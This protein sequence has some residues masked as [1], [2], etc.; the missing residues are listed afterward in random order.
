MECTDEGQCSMNCGPNDNDA[1][2]GCSSS[3]DC[4]GGIGIDYCTSNGI[5]VSVGSCVS[6]TDCTNNIDNS[7]FAIA[8]CIGTLECS[9]DGTCSQ[10][11]DT[12][13][14]TGDTGDGAAPPAEEEGGEEEEVPTNTNYTPCRNNNWCDIDNEY[15]DTINDVCL[16]M[17]QCN[18]LD[19]C[20]DMN[21]VFAIVQ[22]VGTLSCTD[23]Q[24]TKICDGTDSD[25]GEID[26]EE[27]DEEEVPT[28]PCRTMDE[29]SDDGTE[30]CDAIFTGICLKMGSCNVISNCLNRNNLFAAEQCIGTLSCIDNQCS[31]ICNTN[32]SNGDGSGSDPMST[33]CTTDTDCNTYAGTDLVASEERAGD[34]E[35]DD[36]SIGRNGSYCAQGVCMDMGSCN[37]NSD[38]SNPINLFDDIRCAGYLSC[39]SDDVGDGICTRNC[40]E[41]CEDGSRQVQCTVNPCDV[42]PCPGAVS[43]IADYCGNSCT[44]VYYGSSGEASTDCEYFDET[45]ATT[46]I[47]SS[48]SNGEVY[49]SKEGGAV[50]TMEE[51]VGATSTSAVSGGASF[52]HM[53]TIVPAA[54]AIVMASSLLLIISIL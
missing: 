18:I 36:G 2:F 41:L 21:N 6:D 53:N 43:C 47:S 16:Q 35:G 15:C 37:D 22:C 32:G 20:T 30:Y 34:I 45:A 14:T 51:G 49:A 46:T 8:M 10:I 52:Y 9:I 27:I 40:G 50:A 39:G 24:C 12:G 44:A 13:D 3:S 7:P 17:G 28:T 23:G 31:I 4:P 26:E 48:S 25:E 19:D 1:L 42:N 33:T 11:C 29:C 38:C 54:Y 5:C